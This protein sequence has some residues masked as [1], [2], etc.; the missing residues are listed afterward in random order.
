NIYLIRGRSEPG[1]TIR[2]AGRETI[3]P[4]EGSFQLQTTA[5]PGTR[6][7]NVEAEDPRGNSTPYLLSISR[8]G[9]RGKD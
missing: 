8:H 7:V 3:V 1:T 2:V 5:P 9:G 4:A 6:E